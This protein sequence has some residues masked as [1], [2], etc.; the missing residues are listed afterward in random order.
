MPP[1][2]EFVHTLLHGK[3]GYTNGFYEDM[4]AFL[5]AID[6]RN[7]RWLFLIFLLEGVAFLFV[8]ANRRHWERLAAGFAVIGAL[9]FFAERINEVARRH[10]KEFASQQYF[11]ESGAFI[12]AILGMPLIICQFLIVILL[13]KEAALMAVKVKRLELRK[14]YA[15][16]AKQQ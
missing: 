2:D 10:W 6:W 11:D 1:L 5:H 13:V 15:E 12:T 3:H 8:V 7:D 4:Q 9:L 14:S 16:K